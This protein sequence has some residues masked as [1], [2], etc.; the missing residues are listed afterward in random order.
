MVKSDNREAATVIIYNGDGKKVNQLQV[1]PNR[2]TYIG[3]RFKNGTYLFQV[4]QGEK[5]TVVKGL[6]M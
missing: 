4:I 5:R 2:M 3:D 1:S 6:K